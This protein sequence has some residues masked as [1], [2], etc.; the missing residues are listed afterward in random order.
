MEQ[1]QARWLEPREI[2]SVELFISDREVA[3]LNA[4]FDQEEGGDLR[5]EF[6]DLRVHPDHRKDGLA[7]RLANALI[8]LAIDQ[9]AQTLSGSIDSQHSLKILSHILDD[10]QVR[11]SDID[12]TTQKL[13][14]LPITTKEAI[15]MLE[16]AEEFEV[17]TEY[18]EQNLIIHADLTAI[19]ASKF[20]P[21][22]E[23]NSPNYAPAVPL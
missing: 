17:E 10:S 6:G 21:P 18:R 15:E 2:F 3:R 20:E 22:I 16:R 23:L 4:L 19:D 9:G 11:F 1:V 5:V 7:T 12:P 13:V 14:E 8:Y